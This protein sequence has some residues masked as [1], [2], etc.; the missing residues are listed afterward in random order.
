MNSP[1][2]KTF[3]RRHNALFWHIPEDK[4]E[5]ISHE[6]LVEYVLNYGSL[7]EVRELFRVMGIREA[8]KAFYNATG[9]R[10]MNYYPEIYNFFRLYFEKYAQ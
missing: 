5:D 1:E 7:D 3:I 10:R 2:I 6:V 9:R 8:A 4:K